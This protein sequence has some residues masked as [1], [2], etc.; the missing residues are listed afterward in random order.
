[1]IGIKSN[2]IAD[3][4]HWFKSM[5]TGIHDQKEQSAIADEVLF[6]FFDIRKDQRVAF[7]EKRLSESEIVRLKKAAIR[8]NRGEPVQYIT[9]TTD[10]LG[11]TILVK[12]GVLIPRPET[13]EFV[14]WMLPFLNKIKAKSKVPLRMLDIGTGSG[15]IAIALAG[16]FPEAEIFANDISEQALEVTKSNALNNNVVIKYIS[17]DI[18]S[19][20]SSIFPDASLDCIVSNPPYVMKSERVHMAA[21]VLEHEPAVALFVPDEDPLLFYRHIAA[22][23]HKWLKPGGALFFEI[24]E[25]LSAE[26]RD[27][28]LS[29][30]FSE[31]TI[32][33]DIHGKDRFIKSF[34]TAPPSAPP[35]NLQYPAPLY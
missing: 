33:K 27:L 10:F 18:L 25:Q 34:I 9:G 31:V 32:K 8:L 22:K 30:G 5:L 13:E 6:R 17:D 4:Y 24:N 7:P 2:K 12:P 19:A 3:V 16:R 1:M 23:A 26:C 15:C 35:Q 20:D 28:I 11:H 21:N 29:A 14:L